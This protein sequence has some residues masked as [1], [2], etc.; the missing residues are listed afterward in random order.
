MGY[1]SY[2][3][4]NVPELSQATWNM[5][6]RDCKYLSE[7][8][9]EHTDSAGGYYKEEPLK[10]SGCFKYRKAK[11]DK[12]KI[13][14]NGSTGNRINTGDGWKDVE[15]DSDLG[16]ETFIFERKEK[17][18]SFGFCKT[19]RKPYDL[20]VCACL[21]LAKYYFGDMVKVSSD[22]DENDWKPAFDFVMRTLPAGETIVVE[23]KLSGFFK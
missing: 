19:A 5:F 16:H 4:I 14:F 7:H 17:R 20:M 11:F 18:S 15:T 23:L 21:I 3:T 6:I 10:L 22:G 2:Y 9:P 1:T 13:W 8:L 12:N